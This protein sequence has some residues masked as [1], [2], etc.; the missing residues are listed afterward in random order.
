[1]SNDFF[2]ARERMLTRI[3]QTRDASTAGLPHW[4][5][6]ENGKWT[7]TS[8][9]DWTGGAFVGELWLA[10]LADA[11]RFPLSDAHAGLCYSAHGLPPDRRRRLTQAN[12]ASALSSSA[13]LF[14]GNSKIQAKEAW[15]ECQRQ[16]VGLTN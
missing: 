3:A 15:R 10:H 6:A 5:R 14:A 11:Q 4:A 12:T 13:F 8:V 7:F 1:M 2:A 9:G 16:N